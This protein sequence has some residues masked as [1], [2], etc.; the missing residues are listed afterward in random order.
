MAPLRW[1]RRWRAER[2]NP[3]LKC[4]RV[5]HVPVIERREGYVSPWRE[6]FKCS[7]YNRSYRTYVCIGVTQERAACGR[8]GEASSPWDNIEEEGYNSY[9]WPSDMAATFRRDRE[10]WQ[11]TSRRPAK[12]AE[13]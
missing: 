12:S 9:S 4:E 3:A 6:D 10:V 2:R 11:S 7:I 13:P 5:G 1:F 8:C